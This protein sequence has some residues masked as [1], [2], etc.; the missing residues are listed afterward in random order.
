[1]IDITRPM[2]YRS[3][4]FKIKLQVKP[5]VGPHVDIGMDQL[6]IRVGSGEGEAKV[7]RFEHIKSYYD[8]LP[9]NLK[10]ILKN[11]N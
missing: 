7:E 3:F 1:M 11:A 9:P 8:E 5:Y 6:T 4:S 10:G 2:G